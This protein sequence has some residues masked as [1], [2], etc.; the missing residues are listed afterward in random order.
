MKN[1]LFLSFLIG[2]TLAIIFALIYRRH[3]KKCSKKDCKVTRGLKMASCFCAVS[4][5]IGACIGYTGAVLGSTETVIT[6]SEAA[7][8]VEEGT[9]SR[10]QFDELSSGNKKLVKKEGSNWYDTVIT[11]KVVNK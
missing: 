8:L 1:F 7:I 6:Y 4:A 10:S 2:G 3:I 5:F 11:Y 9:I